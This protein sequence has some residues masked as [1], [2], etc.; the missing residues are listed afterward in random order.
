MEP[1]V[2]LID[3]PRNPLETVYLLWQAS[4]VNDELPSPTEV[5]DRRAADEKFNAEVVDTFRRVCDMKIPVAENLN[6]VFLLEGVS[7]AFREQMVRHRIGVRCGDRVGADLIPDLAG[8]SWW[9]QSMRI[10]DM[11]TF[12]SE[13]RYETPASIQAC[14]DFLFSNEERGR[15]TVRSAYHHHMQ[16]TQKLYATMV[17]H[18]IPM[19]DARNVVPLAATHRISW[20]LNLSAL[21]HIVGKRSCWM[22][23][24]GLWEPVVRGMAQ[25]LREKVD[26]VFAGL[27]APPCVKDGLFTK[28]DFALDNRLRVQ[29]EDEIPPCAMWLLHSPQEALESAAAVEPSKWYHDDAAGGWRTKSAVAFE[30]MKGMIARYAPLWDWDPQDLER[31]LACTR[32]GSEPGGDCACDPGVERGVTNFHTQA[33]QADGAPQDQM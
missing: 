19:E 2:T 23:Q 26:P 5:A 4:R 20:S 22:L 9:S 29:G 13:K 28:C 15:V 24:L 21:M 6:F 16:E 3:W 12:A 14:D 7:I 25:E 31:A 18:G 30:R 17:R 32:C 11:G 1:K 33:A 8:S 27:T 10:L